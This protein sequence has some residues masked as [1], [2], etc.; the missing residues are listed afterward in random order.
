MTDYKAPLG[1]RG[2][3]YIFFRELIIRKL[4]SGGIK[5]PA[6]KGLTDWVVFLIG[7]TFSI[8]NDDGVR[9]SREHIRKA[10]IIL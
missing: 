1:E 2:F 7:G 4:F 10:Y 9:G 3:I 6:S 8:S 5:C